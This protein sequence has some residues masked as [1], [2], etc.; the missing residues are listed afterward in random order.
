MR[1]PTLNVQSAFS[2]AVLVLCAL[3]RRLIWALSVCFPIT[4]PSAKGKS[5][6]PQ[7]AYRL[8]VGRLLTQSLLAV[9]SPCNTIRILQSRLPIFTRVPDSQYVDVAFLKFIAH[10]VVAHQ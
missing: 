5:N 8:A 7:A 1:M 10:L 9:G 6:Y 3:R 4:R 2:W